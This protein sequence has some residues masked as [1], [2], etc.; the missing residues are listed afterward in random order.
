[1]SYSVGNDMVMPVA[2]M[3]GGSGCYGQDLPA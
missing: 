1:M 2:P 3:G